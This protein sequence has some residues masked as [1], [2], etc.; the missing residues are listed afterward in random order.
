MENRTK[1]KIALDAMGGDYAPE[2]TVA[3]ALEALQETRNRFSVILVGREDAI[4]KVL[5]KHRINGEA[6]SVVNASEVITFDDIPTVALKTKKQSSIVVG[7]N[8]HKEGKVDAF[9]SAGNTGA[10]LSASTLILGRIDGVGRPTIGTYLP[11]ERGM[12]I[13]LDAGANLDCRPHHL[14]EF[15]IMGSIYARH[16]L[17][18]EKPTVGLLNVGEEASKGGGQLQE[19]FRLLSRSRL[20]FI[21]NVEGGDILQGKAQVVVC[22]GFVG[23][24]VLKFG[25]SVIELVRKRLKEQ[26]HEGLFKKLRAR[27]AY[28][29][30]KTMMKDFDYQEYGGVPVLGVQ[31]VCIIGHGQSTA[32]AVRNMI[33]R[34]EE[35]VVRNINGQIRSAFRAL[36]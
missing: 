34:A 7:M 2:N 21:G 5:Q 19:A 15:A 10:V 9:V 35:M 4:K 31:G 13:L 30:L 20:N 8:L 28:G 17:H 27:V 11:S 26:A 24:V 6:H 29:S 23:N 16:I 1:L 12:C 18:Y 14:L 22:D 3:G 33:L 36:A 25:E 32:K